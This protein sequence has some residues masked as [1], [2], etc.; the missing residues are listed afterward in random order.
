MATTTFS[1]LSILLK[2]YFYY[3]ISTVQDLH[4]R[5]VILAGTATTTVGTAMW[6]NFVYGVG[7]VEYTTPF[8]P[9]MEMDGVAAPS[10]LTPPP[11]TTPTNLV[12][13][14][15]KLGMQLTPS[16]STS[17][18]PDWPANPLRYEMNYSTSTSLSDAGWTDPGP[19]P[20]TIGNSYLIGIR[21]EDND[22]NMSA[23]ATATWNF[24]AGFLPYL[25][26]PGLGYAYQYFTVPSTS[27][28]QSITLFTTN[29]QTSAR[30]VESVGCSLELFDE[31]DLSSLGM[32]P[33]DNG[34]GGYG[35]AGT[36]T[37]SFASSSFV[38]HPD[39]IYHWVFN[40]G[41]GNPSTS[42]GVQFYGT[43]INTAGGMF[44]DPSLVN[45][46]FTV[47]GDSGVLFSN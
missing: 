3:R 28:L 41:T 33:G 22:G 11:L 23:V 26:S 30:F 44:G 5:S 37:F 24:P 36:L 2:P 35:C 14:F 45:A 32:T 4:N 39:H 15:D 42:A 47:A 1:G 10:T 31:Y 21:A 16:F 34:F 17:T 27:T 40:V 13:N 25:L 38:L 7:R 20:L 29:I 43:A 19:I 9:F 8:F 12:M 6:N 46:K 18:D